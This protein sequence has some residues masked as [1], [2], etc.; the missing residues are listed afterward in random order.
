V[1]T[2]G[3]LQP[4]PIPLV[5]WIDISMDF[6]VGLPKSSSK[7]FIMVLVNILSKYAHFCALQHSFKDSMVA[8]VFMDN[9]FKI[10]DVSRKITLWHGVNHNRRNDYKNQL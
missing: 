5:V 8:Q 6:I 1:K 4:L 3:A 9:I 7:I 10:H 2:I